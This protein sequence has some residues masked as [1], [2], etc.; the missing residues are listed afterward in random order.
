M[1]VI[2]TGVC[3]I[4]QYSNPVLANKL[5][6]DT[7]MDAIIDSNVLLIQVVFVAIVS[8]YSQY[9]SLYIGATI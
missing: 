7:F 5:I 4:Q 8:F 6:A 1:D 3:Y 2:D 9:W